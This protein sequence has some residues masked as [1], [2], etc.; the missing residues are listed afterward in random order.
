MTTFRY[1]NLGDVNKSPRK[2]GDM[3]KLEMGNVFY[4]GNSVSSVIEFICSSQT[5]VSTICFASFFLK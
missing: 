4:N 2:V 3:I 5:K 1:K